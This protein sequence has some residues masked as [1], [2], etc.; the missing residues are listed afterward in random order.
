M[1]EKGQIL[2]VDDDLMVAESL[3]AILVSKDYDNIR[4]TNSALEALECLS[5][6]PVDCAILDV[7]MPEMSGFELMDSLDKENMDTLFIIMTGDNS[8]ESAI[9]AVRKGAS[10]YIRKPFEPDELLMRLENVLKQKR[11]NDERKKIEDEK[12]QL[13]SQLIQSQKMEA[14]GTL[15]GGIAHDFNNTLGI[16]IGNT[17]LAFEAIEQGESVAKYLNN[18]LTA[19]TRAEEMVNRLLKFGRIADSKKKAIDLSSAIT[20]SIT[21]LRSSLPTNI[22]ILK[23]IPDEKFTILG[24][25]TQ[26]NQIMI[27]LFTNAAHAIHDADGEIYVK[28]EK[29]DLDKKAALSYGDLT[30]GSYVKLTIADTGDGIDPEIIDRVFDP[31]FT[32]KEIGK[33]TGMGLAVVHG[34]VSNHMGHISVRSIPGKG[35]EF[36]IYLPIVDAVA[37]EIIPEDNTVFKGKGRILFVDDE[38]MIVDTMKTMMELLG[39]RVT[40]FVNSNEAL[41]KFRDNPESYDLVLTDMSMPNMTGAIL[42]EKIKKIRKGIPI[43]MCTGYNEYIDE[44]KARRIGIA[45]IITKPVRTA[46]LAQTI[47]KVFNNNL[48]DRRSSDRYRVKD[49]AFVVSDSNLCDRFNIIDIS[50]S[51]LAFKYH[52]Q[53]DKMD[54]LEGLSIISGDEHVIMDNIA[55]KT[56]SDIVIHE[57]SDFLDVTIRRRG[58]Q[59]DN[60]TNSQAEKLDDF[61]K[62]YTVGMDTN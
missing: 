51:G 46:K 22:K 17:E 53:K 54:D 62:N 58:I 15:S 61:I 40:A 6:S 26:I 27:N 12:R 5:N 60:L 59:F 29:T 1:S 11:A 55:F 21:L 16:I 2:I 57:D 49:E 41:K 9:E 42:A 36:I 30:P 38:S 10:D 3:R 14:I 18:I 4:V 35:T 13:E 52:C 24:D 44:D 39:Y 28:V 19:S 32:T 7:M 31:Y 34:I 56:V 43:I 8:I 48:F 23:N 20:E 45:D 37:T 25:S 50:K 47:R 33:G